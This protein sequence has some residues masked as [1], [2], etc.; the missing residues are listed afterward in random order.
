M[1]HSSNPWPSRRRAVHRML[2]ALIV[3]TLLGCQQSV[4]V[5]TPLT[6]PVWSAQRELQRDRA[7]AQS[8]PVDAQLRPR[9]AAGGDTTRAEQMALG[10]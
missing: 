2:L 1:S 9:L 3:L 8:P 10:N 5:E 4:R 7:L 6:Q